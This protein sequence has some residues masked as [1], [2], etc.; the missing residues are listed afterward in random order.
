MVKLGGDVIGW[1]LDGLMINNMDSVMVGLLTEFLNIT[2]K[3]Y[4]K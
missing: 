1:M 2:D 3:V 4:G